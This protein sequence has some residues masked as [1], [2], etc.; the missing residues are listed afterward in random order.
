MR[1]CAAL[2]LCLAALG[3]PALAQ[4]GASA[5]APKITAA[6][7]G[8]ASDRYPHGALGDPFEWGRLDIS[9]VDRAGKERLY[10]FDMAEEF[11]FEDI[12]PRL[13]DLDA[14][15]RPE[16]VVIQS[17]QD[18]GARLAVY[19]LDAAGTPHLQTATPFQGQRFRW[20]A[21]AGA[22]DIDGDGAIEV[23]LVKQPHLRKELQL[24]R[25]E[26][27]QLRFWAA[28]PRPVTNHRFGEDEIMGGVQAC[29][30]R[31]GLVLA[32]SDWSTTVRVDYDRAA[33]SLRLSDLGRAPTGE[34]FAALLACK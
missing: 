11:V 26:N 25:Y 33:K 23:A 2:A 34:N 32:S 16:V 3:A 29:T 4:S 21:P 5:P 19:A 9:V 17:H 28:A 10:R 18:K 8:G 27:G 6:S 22:L 12:A 15:G 13:W 14:D 20:L 31:P 1:L 30:A 24:Y 7:Y